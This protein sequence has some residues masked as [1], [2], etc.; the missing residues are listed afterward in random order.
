M[1]FLHE[2]TCVC[3]VY[4]IYKQEGTYPPFLLHKKVVKAYKQIIFGLTPR[5]VEFNNLLNSVRQISF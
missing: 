4:I 3:R 2:C 5:D 1:C